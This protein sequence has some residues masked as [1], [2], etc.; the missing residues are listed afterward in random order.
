MRRNLDA[1]SRFQVFLNYPFDE[2]FRPLADAMAFAVVAGGLLPVCAHD[3]TA[4]DRP[5]LEML[6]EA[7]RCCHYSAHDLSRS[8]GEGLRNLSRMNMPIEMGMALFHALQTQRRE[9]RC[10][11]FVPRAHDYTAF[12]SDL[13]GLD[14]RVHNNSD[15]QLLTDMYDWL[16]NVVPAAL[17]NARPAA[18]VLDGFEAFKTRKGRIR[19]GGNGGEPSHAES[20]EVMYQV[21]AEAGWWDWRSNR[22][23][24][25][26]F[27]EVPLALLP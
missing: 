17:F 21:C 12:A 15:T 23:G 7:I 2:E 13:A 6:V 19:G 26:E 22:M 10:L 5:R 16:R 24:K 18:D 1:Y 11:F 25:D 9:H 20:R 3:L 27:P 14:P 4:P 8:E